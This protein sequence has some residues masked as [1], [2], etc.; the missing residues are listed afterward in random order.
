VTEEQA[1]QFLQSIAVTAVELQTHVSEMDAGEMASL[2][3]MESD[4]D[5]LLD[6]L[7]DPTPEVRVASRD[8]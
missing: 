1:I 6:Y 3:E 8:E 7:R 2:W 4:L 5:S